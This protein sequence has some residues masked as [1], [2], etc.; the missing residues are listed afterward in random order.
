M[1]TATRI[2][3]ES[4]ARTRSRV[5]VLGITWRSALIWGVLLLLAILFP[6]VLP[7]HYAFWERFAIDLYISVLFAVSLNVLLGYGGLVSFGHA[8]YFGLGAYGAGI[9]FKKVGL[10]MLA[11]F[12]LGP[13]VA[14]VGAMVF[15]FFCVRRTTIYFAMLTLAFSQIAFAVAFKWRSFTGGDDGLQGVWPPS[16]L[17]I[18]PRSDNYYYFTLGVVVLSLITLYLILHSPFG[19]ALRASRDNARR[20]EMSGLNVRLHQWTAFVIA[21]FFA[22]VAGALSAFFQG[23]VNV[24]ALGVLKSTDPLIMVLLGGMGHFHGPIVGAL[25][26][27]IIFFYVGRQFPFLWQLVVGGVLVLVILA[28]PHGITG[29]LAQRRWRFLRPGLQAKPAP[30]GEEA[31]PSN[32]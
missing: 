28:F 31:A 24:E 5:P 15:G 8:A 21:G 23:S 10:P 1:D 4:T 2:T 11:S 14:L 22:G 16:W 9:L 12:A 18:P 29:F 17:A 6:K 27:K 26:Y 30:G 19:Y 13:F 7:K 25:V 32:D 3:R 20:A